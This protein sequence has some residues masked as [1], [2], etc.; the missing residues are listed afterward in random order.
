MDLRV[1][2]KPKGYSPKTQETT[3]APPNPRGAEL[4]FFPWGKKKLDRD[5]VWML[6]CFCILM[7]GFFR[8]FSQVLF[9]LTLPYFLVLSFFA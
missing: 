6:K 8:P 7:L 5:S 9:V 4:Q 1:G 2:G 3:P